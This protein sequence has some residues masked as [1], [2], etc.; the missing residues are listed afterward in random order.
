MNLKK[1]IS[2]S[3]LLAIGMLLHQITP[4]FIMG[5]KPDFLL[6]MMFIAIMLSE[7]YKMTV[8]I[9]IV[10]GILTAATTSFPGGQIP[11]IIDKII[12]SQVVFLL[13]RIM[14]ERFNN[15]FTMILISIIGTII[16]GTIFLSSALLIFGLPAPFK[17][18]VFTVVIPAAVINTFAVAILY[19][20]VALSLRY[21]HR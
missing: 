2:T 14:R 21:S 19:N 7:D 12:T 5:M 3:L 8:V 1:L 16:S 13:F 11:N 17:V 18:L 4:P 6:A 15:Q 10:S 9:G 20:A